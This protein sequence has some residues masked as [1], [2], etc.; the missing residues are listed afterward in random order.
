MGRLQRKEIDPVFSAL[1]DSHQSLQEWNSSPVSMR[2][3]AQKATP[4]TGGAIDD[5]LH[6]RNELR[7]AWSSATSSSSR[8]PSRLWLDGLGLC[9]WTM[10]EGRIEAAG[11]ST[12]R[13]RWSVGRRTIARWSGKQRTRCQEQTRTCFR[14]GRECVDDRHRW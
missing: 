2:W 10:R 1:R 11:N 8:R 13:R 12:R 5:I 4:V 14:Q 7:A 3:E 9:T 6:G